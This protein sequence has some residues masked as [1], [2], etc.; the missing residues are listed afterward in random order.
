MN[1][2]MKIALLECCERNCEILTPAVVAFVK[3][4]VNTAIEKSEN[5]IDDLFLS[6]INPCFGLLEDFLAKQVAKIDGTEA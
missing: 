4:I 5:K 2:E 1:D 6:I 3:D